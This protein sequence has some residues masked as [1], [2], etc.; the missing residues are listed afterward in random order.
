MNFKKLKEEKGMSGLGVVLLIIIIILAVIIAISLAR[1]IGDT[2]NRFQTMQEREKQSA[3]SV[4]Q[5]VD[6]VGK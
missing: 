4:T 1:F 3:G 2:A 5:I 6:N